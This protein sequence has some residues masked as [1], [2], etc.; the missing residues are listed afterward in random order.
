[1]AIR[2]KVGVVWQKQLIRPVGPMSGSGDIQTAKQWINRPR[3]NLSRGEVAAIRAMVQVLGVPTKQVTIGERVVKSEG[4]EV[5]L[6]A[7]E[8]RRGRGPGSTD[9]SR[10]PKTSPMSGTR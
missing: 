6:A 1:M 4:G 7:D 3:N 8:G 2:E 10:S 5:L 9:R